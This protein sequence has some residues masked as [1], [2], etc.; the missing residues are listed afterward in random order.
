MHTSLLRTAAAYNIPIFV[1]IS[2]ASIPSTVCGKPAHGIVL[3]T[4]AGGTVCLSGT[5]V[6]NMVH[7]TIRMLSPHC[8]I[9]AVE[10]ATAAA[11]AEEEAAI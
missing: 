2:A 7:P 11:E 6:R 3:A 8:P 4:S 10:A 5:R 1:T 9:K